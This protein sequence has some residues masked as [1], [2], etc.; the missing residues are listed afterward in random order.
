MRSLSC[1]I[2]LYHRRVISL[3]TIVNISIFDKNA[4]EVEGL[5]GSVQIPLRSLQ[6]QQLI[7]S[8]Y[9]LTY[10]GRKQEAQIRLRLQLVWSRLVYYQNL[11]LDYDSKIMRIKIEL[12]ELEKYLDLI[13]KPF[14]IL[15]YVE[16]DSNLLKKIHG[17]DTESFAQTSVSVNLPRFSCPNTPVR[18][19]IL[20]STMGKM[21]KKSFLSND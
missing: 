6:N 13:N 14:G 21:I 18:S 15:L 2:Q 17:E 12:Q 9:N 5:Q 7:D 16:I 1:I 3:E 19:S 20:A 4:G 11:V 10:S 8:W